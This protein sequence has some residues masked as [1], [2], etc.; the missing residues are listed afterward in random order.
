MAGRK[1]ASENPCD[2]LE[3]VDAKLAPDFR[4]GR[5]LALMTGRSYPLVVT[6]QVPGSRKRG[7]HLL[8]A[9]FCPFCGTALA[10]KKEKRQ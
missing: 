3:K 8:A 2:C 4:V 5:A 1:R 9:S 7:S 10:N 6:E